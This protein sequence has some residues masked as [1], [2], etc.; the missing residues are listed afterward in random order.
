MPGGASGCADDW[1]LIGGGITGL[2]AAWYLSKLAPT[3][4]ITLYEKSGRLGGWLNSKRV[5]YNG[6]SVLFEQGPRTLRPWSVAGLVTLDM[7]RCG[8]TD[9]RSTAGS[10]GFR[11]D[12]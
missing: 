7:V 6:G 3:V 2:S 8:Q 10:H 12:S 4:P 11:S 9:A 1:R 5:E